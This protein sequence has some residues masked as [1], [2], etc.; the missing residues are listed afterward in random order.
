MINIRTITT[1]S[2]YLLRNF[3]TSCLYT[4]I[5]GYRHRYRLRGTS[6][7]Q[8][9]IFHTGSYVMCDAPTKVSVPFFNSKPGK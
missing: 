2:P 8:P 9:Y 5:V 3:S 4:V 1:I 7:V 6:D